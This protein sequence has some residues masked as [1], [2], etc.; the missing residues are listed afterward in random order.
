MISK[1]KHL[2]PKALANS[3]Q[4]RA[5]RETWVGFA[6]KVLILRFSVQ[7]LCSLCL[8][9]VFCSE[10]INHRD[11][12]NTEAAQRRVPFELLGQSS[13]GHCSVLQTTLTGFITGRTLS[14]FAI[15]FFAIPGL[16]LRSNAG[17][18]LAN[19]FGVSYSYLKATSGSTLVA[20]RAG[21]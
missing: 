8:C 18:R 10:F 11:T 20:R 3:S 19:A 12:E 17:L 13:L 16:S 1:S 4:V 6:S 5:Q 15:T 2:T 7:P 14:G 9:G 21:M